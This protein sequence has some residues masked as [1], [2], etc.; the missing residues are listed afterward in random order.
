MTGFPYRKA[1]FI[2]I[3]GVGMSA[4]A[5]LL[6][7][8][9]VA[10]SGSDEA[11]YPPISDVLAREK[12]DVRTPYAA[13]NIPA[14]A[15]VIVIGKNARLT[16]DQNAEVAEAFRR[17]RPILSFADVL[18]L[19]AAE[20][21]ALVVAGSFGKTTSVSL[22]AHAL[23]ECGQDPSFMIGAAPLSPP[24][25][26][27]IGRSDLLLLEG[28][29]YP[30]S[31][32]DD[33]SKFLHYRPAHLL[34][35]PLAHDHV[36]VFP[37]VESYLAPFERLVDLAPADALV[38][39]STS[40]ELSQRFLASVGR[41]VTTYGVHAG[42]WGVRDIAWGERTRFTIT[43]DGR[44]VTPVETGQLGLHNIENML[45][46]GAFL[47]TLGLVDAAGFA[48]AMA[49]F[50]GIT[51]RLDRKSEKT[52]I[53]MFEGFGSS[54][55]KA[56]S[57]IA[58]MKQH[59]PDKRLVVVFEPHTFS[60][61]NRATL[62]WYDDAFEGAAKVFVWKPAEQGAGTHEQIGQ[63]DILARLA[64]AGYD[65]TGLSDA[66]EAVETIG[67]ALGDDAAVL[68]LTSGPLGGLI[69]TVPAWAETRYP[70]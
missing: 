66:E 67:A 29:E 65:A 68:F 43:R 27:R 23:I 22:M 44:D 16:P 37:T 33:R 21:R 1:H 7:D 32:T 61:R 19:L 39:A 3:G 42:A 54:Y 5:M 69:A 18:G 31:N 13:A 10:V 48:R 62:H 45:G 38:M 11:V 8:V 64:A 24:T 60:W 2:G 46:V 20:R 34:L 55:D 25:A 70:A 57:A 12:L 47:L 56:R 58:A 52:R 41:P 53:P 59:F 36:N 35:T 17:G 4:T 51:R 30:S 63:A 6:R 26:A 50:K 49:S 14:D 28:D 40:G 9:G 15:D